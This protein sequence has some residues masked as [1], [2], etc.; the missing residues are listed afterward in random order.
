MWGLIGK[1]RHVPKVVRPGR[2]FVWRLLMMVGLE[3]PQES[4]DTQLDAVP[5]GT[6][7]CTIRPRVSRGFGL[8]GMGF[9]RTIFG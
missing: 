8:V 7:D 9:A 5:K 2:F 3:G 6:I 1:L 4:G